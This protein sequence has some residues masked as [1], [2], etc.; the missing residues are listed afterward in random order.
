MS[1]ASLRPPPCSA[2]PDNTMRPYHCQPQE[3]AETHGSAPERASQRKTTGAARVLGPRRRLDHGRA[4]GGP[5]AQPALASGRI[6]AAARAVDHVVAIKHKVPVGKVHKMS[7]RP[8]AARVRVS[9]RACAIRGSAGPWHGAA[10]RG[11]ARAPISLKIAH[12]P[13]PR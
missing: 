8:D 7:S 6:I 11:P 9:R 10:P 2:A 12:R 13:R 1:N 3:H 4:R 5:C